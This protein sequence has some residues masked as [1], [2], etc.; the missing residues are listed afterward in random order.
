MAT[1][2]NDTF[3]DTDTTVLTSHT[4][5]TGATWTRQTGENASGQFTVRTNRIYCSTAQAVLQASGAP[6]TPNYDVTATIRVVS[7]VTSI[8]GVVGRASTSART[9]YLAFYNRVTS[10]GAWSV[11]LQRM[12]AGT[13][14]T[15]VENS[16]TS[17]TAGTTHT[18]LLRMVGDQIS[19]YSDGVLVVGPVTDANIT[20]AGKGGVW[21]NTAVTTTTG[22][23]IDTITAAD[24]VTTPV[25]KTF[26]KLQA[27]NRASTY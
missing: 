19:V 6:A 26:A 9:Y 15:L 1:F 13:A 17:F 5:E 14:S 7:T 24:A 22:H 3:T 20:T 27:V 16:I 23:H 18:L 4:G 21:S 25:G 11:G 8:I 2:L 12:L 10:G